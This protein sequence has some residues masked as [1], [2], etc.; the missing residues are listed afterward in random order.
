M[1]TTDQAGSRRNLVTFIKRMCLLWFIIGGITVGVAWLLNRPHQPEVGRV[2][3]VIQPPCDAQILANDLA[4]LHR[5]YQLL[6][7]GD[8]RAS[9]NVLGK[10]YQAIHENEC[11]S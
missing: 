2:V 1:I 5:A 8:K 3:I 7:D 11:A 10:H 6:L 4:V 9:F